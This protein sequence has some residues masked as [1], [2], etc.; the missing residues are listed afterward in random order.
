MIR[1]IEPVVMDVHFPAGVAG[2]NPLDFDV[3]CFLVPR[4][5]G[6]VLV[7][8]AMPGSAA[9]IEAA[10]DRLGAGW[11]D[12]SDVVLTHHHPDHVG[13]LTEVMARSPGGRSLGRGPGPTTDRV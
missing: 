11:T 7:D 13:G 5:S 9:L 2:P 1:P 8:T 10:L 6:L 12:I 3:R 4:A